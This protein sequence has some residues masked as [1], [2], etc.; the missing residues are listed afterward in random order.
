MAVKKERN[1]QTKQNKTNNN[2]NNNN[3]KNTPK[4]VRRQ[5]VLHASVL[6]LRGEKLAQ[7]P[8]VGIELN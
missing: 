7:W 8:H 3:N 2:N 4:S 6:T 1:K 5:G